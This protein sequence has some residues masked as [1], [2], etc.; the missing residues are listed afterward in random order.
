[1][2]KAESM[3]CSSKQRRFSMS[4]SLHRTVD[5]TQINQNVILCLFTALS[6]PEKMSPIKALTMKD[7]ENVS[8]FYQSY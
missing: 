4:K 6:F 2:K 5:L 7:Y 1:M 8:Y 3:S